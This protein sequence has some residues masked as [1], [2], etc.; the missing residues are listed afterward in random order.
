VSFTKQFYPEKQNVLLKCNF[1]FFCSFSGFTFVHY[2]P[3]IKNVK[4]YGL[5]RHV[6]PY[7]LKYEVRSIY[8]HAHENMHVCTQTHTHTPR[9]KAFT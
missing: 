8:Y 4:V 5:L 6:L 1:F 2:L 7:I 3:F 9:V